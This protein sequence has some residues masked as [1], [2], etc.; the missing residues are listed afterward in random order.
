LKPMRSSTTAARPDSVLPRRVNR[1]LTCVALP[2]LLLWACHAPQERA[3]SPQPDPV[4]RYSGGD[5]TT[6]QSAVI[7]EAASDLAAT[8][9]EYAWVREHLSGAKVGRQSLLSRDQHTYDVL[10]VTLAD[11]SR[12]SYYFD[13]SKTLGK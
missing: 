10:E 9:A 5:G 2:L 7:I 11:G 13:I 4:G 6:L 1:A 12:R 8:H 3:A